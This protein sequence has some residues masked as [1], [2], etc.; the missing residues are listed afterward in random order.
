MPGQPQA[1]AL[2][3][4]QQTASGALGWA[5]EWRVTKRQ[6]QAQGPAMQ[7]AGPAWGRVEEAL[8]TAAS[9]KA[10]G[11]VRARW[12]GPGQGWAEGEVPG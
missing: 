8:E 11:L 3:R 9:E 10:P 2:A 6:E 1:G 12:A 5:W 4:K 7:L